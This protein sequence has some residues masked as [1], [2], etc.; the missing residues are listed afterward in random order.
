M[1]DVAAVAGVSKMTASRALRGAPDV[2]RENIDKVERAARE[3]GYVGN[4]LATAF[5]N[6][7]SNLIG[8]VVPSLNNIV[9]AEVMSGIAQGIEGSGLK[10]MFGVTDY[11]P[12]KEFE[13]IKSLL[14]WNPAGLIVTGLDQSDETRE[15]LAASAVPV[16][17]IMDT[18]GDAL[19]AAIGFSHFE[20]GREMAQALIAQGRRRFG[21]VG[22]GLAHDLRAGR[23]LE[24]FK[25]ALEAA[26]LA[27]VAMRHD[28]EHSSTEAGRRLT[29]EILQAHP[30]LDC[31]Y[32]SN[33]DVALGGVF[34]C[35][36][37]GIAVGDAL[38][39]AG[40]NGLEM[41]RTLPVRIA[42]T[43]TPRRQIGFAAGRYLVEAKQGALMRPSHK[44]V[45]PTVLSLP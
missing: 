21:Y 9:F 45:L 31:V 18:D 39:L 14:S 10:P 8:V 37:Q 17:Q 35:L 30:D 32:Y 28:P 22:C 24:G 11:D 23:R 41:T 42:T 29:A 34:S 3:T 40:F 20:A 12:A 27:L 19:G 16:V 33:D 43:I 25:A 44:T 26:G 6:S 7:K 15:L 4:P 1:A 36:A 13:L 38:L 5:S 2:S